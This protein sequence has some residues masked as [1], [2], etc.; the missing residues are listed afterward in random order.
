MIKLFGAS[1]SPFARKAILGAEEKGLEYEHQPVSP[2]EKA[3]WFR[4]ISPV[5]KI[6]A[7]TDGDFFVSDSTAILTYL[8]AIQP[9]PSFYLAEPKDRARVTWFEEFADTVLS[10]QLG[11]IFFER[12]VGPALFK[13]ATDEARVNEIIGTT[14]PP[15]LD[16][17]EQQ[18]GGQYFLYGDTFTVADLAVGSQ[19]V[20]AHHAG[21]APDVARWPQVA[22][23]RE[24]MFARPSFQKA[25]QMD[26]AL[27]EAMSIQAA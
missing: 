4:K 23:W 20:S 21:Y 19:F 17:L 11:N 27:M 10:Q 6:P 25:M 8:D 3:E 24:R 22:A 15:L 2:G 16:Y 14:L 7:M 26:V 5:G 18:I 9:E 12:L 13:K 1:L